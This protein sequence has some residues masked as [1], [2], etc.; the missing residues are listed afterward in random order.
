MHICDYYPG[1]GQ[2][3]TLIGSVFYGGVLGVGVR[4]LGGSGG[5]GVG[6]QMV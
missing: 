5:G 4:W 1:C 6:G 2:S 3:C